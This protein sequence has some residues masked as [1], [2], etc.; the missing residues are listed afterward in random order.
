MELKSSSSPGPD[1]VPSDLL[2]NLCNELSEPL[3][4]I[5]RGSLDLG[6]IPPDLLLVQISPIHKGVSRRLPAASILFVFINIDKRNIS[7]LP[8]QKIGW[9]W[10]PSFFS[11]L[12]I[13]KTSL[14]SSYG[15]SNSQPYILAT[16]PSML[17]HDNE[18]F[19]RILSKL[20]MN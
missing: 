5:W 3:Y 7:T 10:Q 8:A 13:K 2:R 14:K 6:Y 11:L 20:A 12:I 9:R 18:H 19:Q 16:L 4:L 15:L 1:G 17:G